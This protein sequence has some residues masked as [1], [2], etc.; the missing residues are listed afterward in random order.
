MATPSRAPRA[1][2]TMISRVVIAV[3]S[4][5]PELRH[6]ATPSS[7]TRLSFG[8]TNSGMPSRPGPHCQAARNRSSS[9]ALPSVGLF[10]AF[11]WAPYCLAATSSA[12]TKRLV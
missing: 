12:S 10:R 1:K 4:S 5:R 8:R 11:I 3:C 9:T 7:S 2:P 6:M